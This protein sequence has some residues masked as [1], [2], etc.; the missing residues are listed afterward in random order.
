MLYR[1]LKHFPTLLVLDIQKVQRALGIYRAALADDPLIKSRAMRRQLGV[2]LSPYLS[3][4]HLVSFAN[5]LRSGR[6]A[7]LFGD[8]DGK[9]PGDV[10]PNLPQG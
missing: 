2:R 1:S 5:F 7:V 9:E 4:L 6:S 8:K 3:G 10:E